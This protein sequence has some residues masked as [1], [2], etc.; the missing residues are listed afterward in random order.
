[1]NLGELKLFR[2][3]LGYS[4][5]GGNYNKDFGEYWGKYQFGSARR[6]DIEKMLGLHH[7]TRSEFSPQMQEWF[8]DTH[9]N[10][11]ESRIFVENLDKYFGKT[12]TGKSNKIT[13]KINKYGLIAGA[14]LGGFTGMKNYLT[15]NGNYDPKDSLETHISDYI[16]KFSDLMEKKTSLMNKSQ[17]SN[18][19]QSLPGSLSVLLDRLY[20]QMNE[21]SKV[22]QS[23]E[24]IHKGNV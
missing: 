2:E 8:F 6:I 4:E 17:T 18:Q 14:H 3:A 7:L 10:D 11:Y 12:I 21:L 13:A 22:I 9:I 1:M 19:I 20:L 23:I 15:S 24:E 5:S 16:A